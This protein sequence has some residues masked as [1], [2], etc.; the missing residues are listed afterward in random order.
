MLVMGS[1]PL[2]PF[3]YMGTAAS[4]PWVPGLGEGHRW[5]PRGLGLRVSHRQQLQPVFPS[6]LL[7]CP[8]WFPKAEQGP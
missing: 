1:V 8:P 7:T 5:L 6:G 3:N 2:S 4:G